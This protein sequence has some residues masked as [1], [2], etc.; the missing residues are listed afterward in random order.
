MSRAEEQIITFAL[1]GTLVKVISLGNKLSHS[2][3][4]A[5]RVDQTVPLWGDGW[6]RFFFFF[7]VVALQ[8]SMLVWK[9]PDSPSPGAA[10]VPYQNWF[11]SYL[12]DWLNAHRLLKGTRDVS[13]HQFQAEACCFSLISTQLQQETH[14]IILLPVTSSWSCQNMSIDGG[15]VL[16][17]RCRRLISRYHSAETQ[18]KFDRR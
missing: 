8:F 7:F 1:S 5:S 17:R 4:R 14:G 2:S 3:W 16:S 9:C 18:L 6:I 11:L 13:V 15:P 10:R 12:S